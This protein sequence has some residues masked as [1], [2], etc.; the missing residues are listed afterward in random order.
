MRSTA[1]PRRPSESAS[2]RKGRYPSRPMY[3]SRSS[4]PEP[5]AVTT[6]PTR[7]DAE[8]FFGMVSVPASTCPPGVGTE[9]FTAVYGASAGAE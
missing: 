7:C 2:W 3:S 5:V 9:T 1:M 8:A 4:G 6:A